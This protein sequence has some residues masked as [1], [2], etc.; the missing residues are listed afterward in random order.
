MK[1]ALLF[2]KTEREIPYRE[3]LDRVGLD[4]IPFTPDSSESL[5]TVR[6]ILMTGGT[7]VDPSLSGET[8]H[9]ETEAPDRER[10]DYESAILREAISRDLPVLA[11][12]RGLQL[13]NVV[14]GGTLHQHIEN[15]RNTA[16]EVDLTPPFKSIFGA[17]RISVNS[18]HHQAVRELGKGLIVTAR[19]PADGVIEGLA[20]PGHRFVIAVQWHPED[21]IDDPVQLRLFEAFR[22]AF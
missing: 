3:A 6:G 17:A 5:D 1:A 21:M 12:C 20:L 4:A 2:R 14:Y 11:I 15:H 9:P 10:D 8:P 22:N 16:H 13:M 19:D 7:D 18:R